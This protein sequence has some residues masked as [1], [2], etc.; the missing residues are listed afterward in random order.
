MIKIKKKMDPNF[1]GLK[2]NFFNNCKHLVDEG[3]SMLGWADPFYPDTIIPEHIREATIKAI[4]E[5]RSHYTLP[6]LKIIMV[7]VLI[8]IKKLL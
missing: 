4:L 7:Y 3:I 8:P 1:A 5:Q 6:N 2:D